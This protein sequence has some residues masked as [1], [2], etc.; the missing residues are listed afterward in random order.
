MRVCLDR[1]TE[2]P[3]KTK[4]CQFY[5]T[6]L[7]NEQILWLEVPMHYSMSMAVSCGLKN[8]ICE[9]FDGFWW[10]WATDLPHV[11]LKIVFA[12][13]KYQIQVVLLVYHFLKPKGLK[14]KLMR[15][16]LFTVDK[17]QLFGKKIQVTYSTTFGCLIPLRRE[18]SLMAVL[19]TPSSSFSNLIFLRATIYSLKDSLSE[20]LW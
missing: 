6:L 20:D 4:I 8:L 16:L 2:C 11:L 18:I 7:V 3:C 1:Q 12:V 15:M 13:L 17:H 5:V 19:G 10:Q 9:L 14:I